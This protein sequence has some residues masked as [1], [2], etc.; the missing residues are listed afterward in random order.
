AA[1]AQLGLLHAVVPEAGLDVAAGELAATLAR[2]PAAAVTLG[3]Q[4][5]TQQLAMNRA[6]AYD[7]ALDQLMHELR[8]HEAGTL[9]ATEPRER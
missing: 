7:Y 3:K 4:G 9:A 8:V 1:M 5:F 2:W 6:D